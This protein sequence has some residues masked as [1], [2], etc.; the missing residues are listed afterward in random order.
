MSETTAVEASLVDASRAIAD[1]LSPKEDPQTPSTQPEPSSE[2][3][4]QAP[5]APEQESEQV[6]SDAPEETPEAPPAPRLLKVGELE[7]PEEEVI[8]GYLRTSDYTKKTQA[9]AEEKRKFEA[10]EAQQIRS[11]RHQYADRLQQADEIL[12]AMHPANPNWEQRATQVSPEQLAAEVTEWDKTQRALAKIREERAT[13]A[14]QEQEDAQRGFTQYVE[15]E[16]AKIIEAIPEFGD[17]TKAPKLRDSLKSFAQERYGFSPEE[18]GKV[19]DSR[20]VRLLHDALQFSQQKAKAPDVKQT[21]KTAVTT[22]GPGA[23]QS[24]RKSGVSDLVDKAVKTGR[25]DHAAAAIKALMTT[26]PAA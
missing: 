5:A 9:L 26:K 18:F 25:E 8:K 10:E 2:T 4:Q 17:T 12:S 3:T 7:L 22:I 21:I 13:I 16:N 6:K 24:E 19:T 20:L 23:K 11:V 14:T 15:L 1:L